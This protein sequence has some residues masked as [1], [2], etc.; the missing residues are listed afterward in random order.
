MDQTNQSKVNA[1]L[2]TLFNMTCDVDSYP[3]AMVHWEADGERVSNDTVVIVDTSM[4]GA[5]VTYTCVAVNEINGA[6]RSATNSINVI[7]QGEILYSYVSILYTEL[8]PPWLDSR[9]V[10][11]VRTTDCTNIAKAP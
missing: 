2:N 6:N 7:V 4:P 11:E 5:I 3:P 9:Y 1:T 10:M 8:E